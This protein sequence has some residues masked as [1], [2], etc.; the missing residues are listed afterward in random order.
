MWL[1]LGIASA[2]FLGV[3][4][5]FKKWSVDDNAVPEVLFLSTCFGAS[6][7]L[8]VFVL[9]RVFP[10]E[11]S[12]VSLY[13]GFPSAVEHIFIVAKT[14]LVSISWITAYVALKHLP[15]SIVSPIR[16]SAP[17]WTLMG[18]VLLFGEQLRPLH[19]LGIF[20]TFISYYLFSVLG[21]REG[22]RF[23]RNRYIALVFVA[24]VTGALSALYDKY[25]LQAVHIPPVTL[26]TWF[27]FYLVGTTGIIM[28]LLRRR[29][30][31]KSV[32]F[33]WRMTVPLIGVFLIVA[34]YLYFRALSETE[35][36]IAVLSMIRR[37][38][39]VIS[40]VTGGI[41]FREQN[42]RKKAVPLLGVLI[43]IAL[44]LIGKH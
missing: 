36:L 6:L 42:K 16:A 34:D 33:K 8:P 37:S 7:M 3:Y 9:S 1:Y 10:T 12:S 25:L 19:W 40:F 30:L 17:L 29:R 31:E 24:T 39:V 4:D 35:A 43:G 22:I 5:V 44:L 38:S 13:A 18:A 23:F 32:T 27:S 21:K 14:V 11:M 26:Q 2:L 15:I 41:L 28:V 20:V